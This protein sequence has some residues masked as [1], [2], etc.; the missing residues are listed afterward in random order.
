MKRCAT[1]LLA[2]ELWLRAGSL[3]AQTH[4]ARPV[5]KLI[6]VW[7][8]ENAF[9]PTVRGELTIIREAEGWR[10]SVS[11]LE[12][13]V[14]HRGDSVSFALPGNL[15]SFRGSLMPGGRSIHGWWI[16]PLGV[17]FSQQFATPIELQVLRP[18][19]WRGTIV[20]LD[21]RFDLY[22]AIWR[23]AD[24][25][26]L[27]AFRNPQF[28]S[29]GSAS[30]F[31]IE[32]GEDSIRFT[33]PPDTT[34]PQTRYS[35][36]ID[37]AQAQIT[38]MWP[39]LGRVI[40]LTPRD[41]AQAVSLFPRVPPGAAWKY[42]QPQAEDDGWLTGRASAYGMDEAVLER[43][44][45]RI[46]DT[47]M[48]VSRSPFIHSILIARHGHLVLEE[49]FMGYGP[50]TPHD[51]RSA[52]KT[53]ASVMVGAAMLRGVSIGPDTRLYPLIGSL[54]AGAPADPRRD[55]ITLAH[56]MSHTTGLACDDNEDDSPGNEETMQQQTAQPDWWRYTL[57]L[58]MTFEPG[59]HYA[60][61]SAT[62][63]L[64][65]AALTA[66]THTW[67]PEYFD[68]TVA[69]PLQFGRYYYNLQPTLEGYLGGGLQVRPR[70][71]LKIGQVY[72][73]GGLWNGRRIVSA[74]WVRRSTMQ[75]VADTAQSRDGF[76]WH[77]G[78]VTSG[79]RSYREYEANGNGGQFVI[80][81]PELDLAVTFTAGNYLAYGVWGHFR[82]DLVANVIIPAI[83]DR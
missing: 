42:R 32:V 53:Y 57:D 11:S 52:A 75:Q 81:L 27:G 62:M 5:D 49:Y 15:G 65:G 63:S 7:A 83:K 35:A 20:P 79:G 80:V 2:M 36:S 29:R 77:R 14:R 41:S 47:T 13:P 33:A 10:A 45:Q 40:V 66:A 70:D 71:L 61:C 76:A 38:M 3:A 73:A 55:R 48:L 39:Y 31:R 78:V 30:Q 26:L 51:T 17:T 12:V 4:A 34:E 43:M 9:G 25:V 37:S 74:D 18:G 6:G 24:G 68:R 72:V 59:T 82:D 8:S 58:P 64:V 69:R 19:A 1:I 50:D 22:L 44:V 60:Y 46:A 67:L 16:Q 21:D 54:G 56:L 23:R 28:N